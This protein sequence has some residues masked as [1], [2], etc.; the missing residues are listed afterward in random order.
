MEEIEAEKPVR[1]D[2]RDVYGELLNVGQVLT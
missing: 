2:I 1:D